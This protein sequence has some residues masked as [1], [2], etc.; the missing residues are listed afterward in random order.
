MM[1]DISDA[2]KLLRLAHLKRDREFKRLL[3][4]GWRLS[5][6]ADH[7]GISRQRAQQIAVKLKGI[8]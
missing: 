1:T 8:I 3:N 4:K 2:L 7:F 6:L 5:R